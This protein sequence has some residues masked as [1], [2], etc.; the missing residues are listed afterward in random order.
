MISAPTR[1]FIEMLELNDDAVA[2]TSPGGDIFQAN[3]KFCRLTGYS[4]EQLKAMT[5][6]DLTPEKWLGFENQKVIEA[7]NNG[8]AQYNKEYILA[9]GTIQPISIDI[10]LLNEAK[11]GHRGMWAIVTPI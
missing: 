2:A 9:N 5:Y 6:H 8:H 10:F 4:L 1:S 11:D 7:F 3:E